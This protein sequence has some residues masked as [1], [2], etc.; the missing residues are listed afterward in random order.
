MKHEIDLKQRRS[1]FGGFEDRED[2]VAKNAGSLQKL[3]AA[4]T[5]IQ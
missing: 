2:Y 3:K 4:P 5:D 1:S